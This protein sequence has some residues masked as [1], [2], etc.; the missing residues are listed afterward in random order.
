VR[1]LG[2]L[3]VD[4]LETRSLADRKA[5]LVLQLLAFARGRRVS[6]AALVD[7]LWG[8]SPPARPADQVAVLISRLRRALGRDCI[9]YSEHGYGLQYGWLDLDELA[10]VS[11]EAERRRA[12]GD[13]NGALAASRVALAL[14]RGPLPEPASEADW[15]LADRAAATRLIQRTRSVGA[16]AMLDAGEW[17]DALEL[18]ESD[19]EASHYDEDAVRH[20]MRA[21]VLA[22]RPALALAVYAD[23]RATLADDLGADPSAETSDL[24]EAILRGDVVT[25]PPKAVM[26]MSGVVGRQEQLG[27]LDGLADRAPGNGMRIV[28][29]AGE[30]GIG[31]TTLV[32]AWARRRSAAGETV[33]FGTCGALDR[34]APLDVLLAAI[35]EHLRRA[36]DPVALLADDAP[37]LSPLL[38]VAELPA[39]FAQRAPDPFLGPATLYA[40]I[41]SVLERIGG[42]QGMVLVIDDAHL[43]GPAL[44]E[45][46]S[47]ALR[48]S[49]RLLVVAASRLGEGTPFP[50]TDDI[51]LG[52]LGRQDTAELVGEERASDLY[53]RSGG[54][55][56]LL[57]ELAN[58]SALS[59]GVIPPSLVASVELRC[60]Q[61]GSA[62]DVLRAA[63]VLGTHLDI[64]LLASVLGRPTLEVL[65]HAELAKTRQ[66][67]VE[68]GGRYAF[69]HELM[70]EALAAGASSGRAALLHREA[71]RILAERP[72]SDPV[73]VAE[74][75]RLGGDLV[76]AALSLRVA[77]QRAS[78]RF[79]HATAEALLDQS[80]ALHAEND[81][82]LERARVRTRR[83]R[84]REAQLDVE[85]AD[86]GAEGYE[87]GAWAAYFDRRFDDAIQF[88]HDGEI[89]AAD[90]EVQARCLTVGGRTLHAKGDLDG[91]EQKLTAAIS[92]SVGPDRLTAAAWLGVLKS[93]RSSTEEA[94][95]LLRPVA[96]PGAGVDLTSAT[97]HALLFTGHAHALAGRPQ[98]A[99][100][101]FGQYNEEVVRRQVPRFSGRGV[102]MS[103]W[104]LRNIGAPQAAIDAHQEALDIAAV[105]DGMVE[106]HIA[107]LEDLAEERLRV[108]DPAGAMALVDEASQWFDGDLVFGWRLSLKLSLLRARIALQCGE[109]DRALERMTELVSAA[110]QMG[111]PRYSSVGRLLAHQARAALGEP[112][113]LAMVHRDLAAVEAN[114]LLEAWWLAG[115]T[116]VALGDESLIRR[117]EVL[118][119]DLARASGET[120]ADGLRAEADR[121]LV[122]WRV[123][124]R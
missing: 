121:Q 100:A 103:G 124:M 37:L 122:G 38:G 80:L 57:S 32:S 27:I 50:S 40:A 82:L 79:D 11:A 88:A 70:R 12:D 101:A 29:V 74:H 42:D 105:G 119:D 64:D 47:F 20:V 55:P 59:E 54:H 16:A 110:D 61:L 34:S 94:I 66:F 41:T 17:L 120:Y 25:K 2:E 73:R 65:S 81:V 113:D 21:H 67:L 39:K 49:P 107:A 83:G 92:Q 72:A 45:W 78:E 46:A 68:R 112:V 91:A 8:E 3:A 7:A 89:S 102:N 71:G 31:K 84:Y 95:N 76:Q 117:A 51:V 13:V 1:V 98:E 114:V 111:V 96:H 60:N 52:P 85:A 43:A 26:P 115:Q 18:A 6:T 9:D 28:V 90:A 97:L 104:V 4:G 24:H 86:R 14:I 123:R 22:G 33:M 56:L 58:S 48:R 15:V 36:P 116:G 63:A 19:L 23:L 75:S 108:E 93:H 118:A 53:L 69:R 30:A 106:M 35:A 109:P 5:R 10:S 77:A 44:A 87:V 62:A 99:I